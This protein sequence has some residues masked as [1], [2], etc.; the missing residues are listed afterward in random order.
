MLMKLSVLMNAMIPLLCH[1][2]YARNIL[3]TENFLLEIY[4]KLLGIFDADL[5]NKLYETSLSNISKNAKKNR[6]L[7]QMQDIRGINETTHAL[8]C[9]KNIILNIIPKYVFSDN[10]IH[11][12]FKSIQMNTGLTTGPLYGVICICKPFELLGHLIESMS[13]IRQSAAKLNIKRKEMIKSIKKVQRLS[14]MGVGYKR[15]RSGRLSK[16]SIF[17]DEDIVY[18]L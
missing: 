18:S 16:E 8:S 11:F 13:S 7:W 6:E 15:I 2:M 1:F 17:R 9:V 3:N 4:D 12:N 10:L 14:R 5:Y